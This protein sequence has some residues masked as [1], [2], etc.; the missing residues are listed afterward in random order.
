MKCLAAKHCKKPEDVHLFVFL[1]VQWSPDA[2]KILFGIA[3]GE[4]QV[5]DNVGNFIVSP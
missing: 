1:S 4:V 5:F 3:N 2:K